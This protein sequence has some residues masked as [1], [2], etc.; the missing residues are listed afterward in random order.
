MYSLPLPYDTPFYF[1]LFHPLSLFD[2]RDNLVFRSAS[3]VWFIELCKAHSD[4]LSGTAF[5]LHGI[6]SAY[7]GQTT[8]TEFVESIRCDSFRI[9]SFLAHLEI[10]F[11]TCLSR[12]IHAQGIR[13]YCTLTLS[14]D[15][16]S[17][18]ESLLS[19]LLCFHRQNLFYALSNNV[20]EKVRLR[21]AKSSE[22]QKTCWQSQQVCF[23]LDDSTGTQSNCISGD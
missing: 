20:F 12:A 23:G 7:R 2:G 16:Q 5:I 3:D 8:D 17:T 4:T 18:F 22:V 13:K 9:P 14:A 19:M 1:R 21:H 15:F 11:T 10:C 6:L